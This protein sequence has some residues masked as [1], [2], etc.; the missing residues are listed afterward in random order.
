MSNEGHLVELKQSRQLGSISRE[1]YWLEVQKSLN[2]LSSLQSVFSSKVSKLEVLSDGLTLEY[3]LKPD[4]KLSM[5]IEPKDLRSA[6]M[7]IICE[8]SYEPILSKILFHTGINARTFVDVGAN[9]GFYS[10]SLAIRN[11]EVEIISVEPNAEVS[12]ILA[13]NIKINNLDKRITIV[14]SAVGSIV[15]ES[16]TLFIPKITDTGGGSLN[17]L[18][19]EEGKPITREIKVDTLDNLISN[20]EPVDLMKID[21]EGFEFEVIKGSENLIEKWHPII[22]VELLRKWMAPFNSHP[23]D[24]VNFLSNRDY[25]CFAIGEEKISMTAFIDEGTSETN[26]IFVHSSDKSNLEILEEYTL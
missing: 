17:N 13:R 20:M 16:R 24:V 23:Q 14:N 25:L 12:S 18:H 2:N 6:P 7:T 11:P 5:I 15:E 1:T 3:F 19:H 10:L 26:F 21:V 9:A 8:G 22:F 4:S